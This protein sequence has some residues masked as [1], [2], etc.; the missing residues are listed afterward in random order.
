MTA[1]PCPAGHDDLWTVTE[2]IPTLMMDGKPESEHTVR[3]A[4]RGVM[5]IILVV[6]L[7]LI[8]AA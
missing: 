5:L 4:S 8:R 1:S 2:A 6:Q 7:L 3:W